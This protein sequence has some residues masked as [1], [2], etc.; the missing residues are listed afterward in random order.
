MTA[1][2]G[3]FVLHGAIL[4]MKSEEEL[5][6]TE[7]GY[8]VCSDGFSEGVFEELPEAYADWPL[9]DCW[10]N[11]IVPGFID[12]RENA[13]LANL[14]GLGSY[15]SEEAFYEQYAALEAE[16][17][18]SD[19]QYETRTF[20]AFIENI[21]IGPA[22]RALINAGSDYAA[23][24]RLARMLDETGLGGLVG[25]EVHAGDDPAE[26]LGNAAKFIKRVRR[27]RLANT[28][29][30]LLADPAGIPDELH[31]GLKKLAGETNVPV[32]SAQ[33]PLRGC[34]ADF[35]RAEADRAGSLEELFAALTLKPVQLFGR[36]GSFL[37]VYEFDAIILSDVNLDTMRELSP[38]ERLL[39]VL[40]FGDD[41]SVVGKFVNGWK[42]Y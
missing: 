13:M 7:D 5:F 28:S 29:P 6:E 40:N 18:A 34:H 21:Y 31:E 30:A 4:F 20:D 41:R 15:L 33:E 35:V 26:A 39:R 19:R 36:V 2:D 22:T 16:L 9:I 27:R 38:S 1:D 32:L 11:L 37:P 24:A 42:V 8:L 14:R 10:E 12:T 23:A 3:R 17:I 25:L